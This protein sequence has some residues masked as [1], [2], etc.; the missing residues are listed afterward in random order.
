MSRP[1]P[2]VPPKL[3]LFDC[4]GWAERL[5]K[6]IRAGEPIT[7]AIASAEAYARDVRDTECA[8]EGAGK[9]GQGAAQIRACATPADVILRWQDAAVAEFGSGKEFTDR[10]LAR[11][12]TRMYREVRATQMGLAASEAAAQAETATDETMAAKWRAAAQNLDAMRRSISD[13]GFVPVP[14]P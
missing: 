4:E 5:V 6:R 9:V 8:R 2:L 10:K 13:G 3:P 7:E 12:L 1:R 11:F 14:N